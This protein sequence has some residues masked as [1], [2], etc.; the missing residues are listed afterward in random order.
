MN[1]TLTEDEQARV[2]AFKDKALSSSE[3][4]STSEWIAQTPGAQEFLERLDQTDLPFAE[5]MSPMLNIPIPEATISTV[6]SQSIPRTLPWGRAVAALLLLGAGITIGSIANNTF[7]QGEDRSASW[8]AQ[9]ANYQQLYV[10]P[11]VEVAGPVDFPALE[12]MMETEL[13]QSINIPNFDD[14][15]VA[16]RRGQLLQVDGNPLIQLAYLPNESGLPIAFCIMKDATATAAAPSAGRS[17]GLNY[18]SWSQNG[19][20]FVLLGSGSESQIEALAKRARAQ[21]NPV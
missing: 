4:A 9:V 21:I 20:R 16:F 19:L 6:G 13:E 17:H 15:G 12:T 18:E 8:V 5:A 1:I 2:L 14:L 7:E 11:T 10:R 3:M